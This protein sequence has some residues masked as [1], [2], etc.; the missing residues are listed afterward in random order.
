MVL[1]GFIILNLTHA[2]YFNIFTHSLPFG[3]YMKIQGPPQRGDYA[4][5]CLTHEIARF[6]INRDYLAQ[7]QCDTGTVMV[8]KM[9]K[10]VPGDRFAVKNGFLELNGQSYR[11]MD[12]DSNGRP[13]RIFYQ[14]KEGVL[15]KEKYFLLSDFVQNSW[16]SR[17]WGPVGIQFLLKPLWIIASKIPFAAL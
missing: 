16:D 17:Y 12:R 14:Q 10:G 5:T 9:I 4:A 1:S 3:I 7:G 6:G 15:D 11:I 8:L 2:V 13:L